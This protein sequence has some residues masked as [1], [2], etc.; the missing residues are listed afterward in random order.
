MLIFRV[1]KGVEEYRKTGDI[2]SAGAVA[3]KSGMNECVQI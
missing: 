2:E 3:A 1:V